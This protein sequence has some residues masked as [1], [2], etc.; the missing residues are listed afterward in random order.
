MSAS[1]QTMGLGLR[2]ALVTGGAGF[3]GSA[4]VRQLL[5]EG[6][7]VTVAS[8]SA[9]RAELPTGVRAISLDLTDAAALE[10]AAAGM[11][12]IFHV[13]ALA[14]VWGKREDFYNANVIGTRNVI[15]AALAN[16]VPRLVHTSSPSVCFDGRDHVNASND[17]PLATRFLCAYAE[18]KAIAEREMLAAN[19]SVSAGGTTLS[20]CALRPHLIVGPGD[21]HIMPRLIERARQGRLMIIGDGKNEV[22]VTDVEN[23]AHA[24]LC[25]ARALEPGAAC[26]GRA[27]FVGQEQPV[28]IWEWVTS[29][30]GRL[31]VPA[32][33]R[34]VS[35]RTAYFIGALCEV[36]WRA[37]PLKGE[38]PMTRFVAM[39]MSTSH[40]Y[41]LE[42]IR[43]DLAY[44]ERVA[45]DELTSR[46]AQD[47]NRIQV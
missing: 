9:E 23:A 20:T 21:P 18:T 14:G 1:E 25:A 39:Q 6:V 40:S 46:I 15:A 2:R 24:H 8:R 30:F 44:S 35:R 13:A 43:R 41:R 3:L 12:A 37:L 22:S 5:S 7:E 33:T 47:V 29:L 31:G 27:Y 42:P 45:L 34:H 36:I 19:G 32:P 11:D 17:L 16:G 4:I 26:A 28:L 38:P 10:S